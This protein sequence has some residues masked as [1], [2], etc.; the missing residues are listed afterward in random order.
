M[1]E[2]NLQLFGG[3]GSSSRSAGG[4]SGGGLSETSSASGGER[5][6]SISDLENSLSGTTDPNFGAF[7]SA[8]D[9]EVERAQ[10]IRDVAEQARQVG[11]LGDWTRSALEGERADV[12]SQLDSMP[13]ERTASEWGKTEG[14]RE[15]LSA[16]DYVLNQD[17]SSGGTNPSDVNIVI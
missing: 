16:L 7:E 1:F 5:F 11:K 8:Y 3:R 4:A 15:R 2:M 10:E 14:L 12:Q 9:T 17:Y 6:G 13:A